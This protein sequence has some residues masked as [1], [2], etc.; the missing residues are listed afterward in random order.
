VIYAELSAD[1][2]RTVEAAVA[3][4][5]GGGLLVHPTAGVYGIGGRPGAGLE[6]EVARLKGRP[7]GPGLVHLVAD[8]EAIRRAWPHAAWPPL[9]DRLARA[10]WPGL[11][12][13]VLEDGTEHGVAVRVEPHPFTRRILRRWG[14]ALGST[15]LN[16]SGSPPAAYAESAR[17]V[18]A[19]FPD[20]EVPVLFVDA[21]RL[22]GPP[23]STLV[24]V[25]ARDGGPWEVLRVGAIPGER[26]ARL[27]DPTAR[28]SGAPGGAN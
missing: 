5:E 12:T 3:H 24:R 16:L 28:R 15:S 2:D 21:G 26:I 22:P 20:A 8:V 23:P 1:R 9:A 10:L 4:L 11:L 7:P 6:A 14:G 13:L 18:L 17:E 19:A 25:P 27:A